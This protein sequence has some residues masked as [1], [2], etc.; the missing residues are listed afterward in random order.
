MSESAD[1]ETRVQEALAHLYDVAFLERSPLGEALGLPRRRGAGAA[2][3]RR[4][5]ETIERLKPP[6]DV[7]VESVAWK[8]YRVLHLRYVRSLS[9]AAVANELGLSTRQTQRVHAA[10]VAAV[11]AMLGEA[12]GAEDGGEAREADPPP[13]EA[14]NPPLEALLDGE[15]AAIL[16]C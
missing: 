1:G 2:L 14:T 15:I 11:A 9:V 5:L 13:T 16:A 3:H 6:R 4:L 8:I 7:A 10:A 12:G